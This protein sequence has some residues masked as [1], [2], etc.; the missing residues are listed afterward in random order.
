MLE[1][2]SKNETE[3][4]KDSEAFNL[5]KNISRAAGEF[6]HRKVDFNDLKRLKEI[7]KAQEKLNKAARTFIKNINEILEK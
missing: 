1:E 3:E 5:H 7:V 2:N 4:W 6:I